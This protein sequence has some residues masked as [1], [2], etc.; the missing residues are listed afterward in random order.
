MFKKAEGFAQAVQDKG[1]VDTD[2]HELSSLIKDTFTRRRAKVFYAETLSGV[3]GESASPVQ[4]EP[5]AQAPTFKSVVSTGGVFTTSTYTLGGPVQVDL[6]D[7]KAAIDPYLLLFTEEEAGKINVSFET[8][9][10]AE[11]V[12]G[13]QEVLTL[14]DIP[15]DEQYAQ[16][17]GNCTKMLYA[18]MLGIP[19][20]QLELAQGEYVK[21]TITYDGVDYVYQI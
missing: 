3:I 13:M 14:I 19:R 12:V 21:V 17:K 1:T 10:T 15:N 2:T 5:V 9:S 7:Q 8:N 20:E 4:E 18:Y 16:V 11:N 6:D